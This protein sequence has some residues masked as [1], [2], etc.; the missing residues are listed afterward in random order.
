M[1]S[2]APEHSQTIL[3]PPSFR[4]AP[5]RWSNQGRRIAARVGLGKIVPIA[6]HRRSLVLPNHPGAP[7]RHSP[8]PPHKAFAAAAQKEP[9]AER[10]WI[11]E[12]LE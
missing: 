9:R 5:G 3:T 7:G 12:E 11:E 6:M 8:P 1:T 4:C 2:K 10:G